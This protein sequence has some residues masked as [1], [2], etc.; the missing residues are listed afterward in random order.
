M[1]T[2]HDS[3]AVN[4][5]KK[6]HGRPPKRSV[7]AR[8]SDEAWIRDWKAKHVAQLCRQGPAYAHYYAIRATWRKKK[9]ARLRLKA[10]RA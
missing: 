9:N 3:L 4:A 1:A 5:F 8:S 6:A 10:A 2:T 7:D